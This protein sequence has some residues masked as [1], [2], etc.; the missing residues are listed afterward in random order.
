[1]AR[2]RLPHIFII[3]G[4]PGSGK[5]TL[6]TTLVEL[7]HKDARPVYH[8]PEEALGFSYTHWYWPGITKARLSLMESAL[9][10]VEEESRRHLGAVFV[11]NRFHLSLRISL[12]E[13]SPDAG[14]QERF[15]RIIDRLRLLNVLVLLLQL[16]KWKIA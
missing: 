15:S 13:S 10:F 12:N 3:E 4:I 6:T 5:N 8:Y 9:D 16:E 14:V 2:T 1:M 7:L 11:F